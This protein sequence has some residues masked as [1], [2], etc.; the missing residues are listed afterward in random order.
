MM[1]DDGSNEALKNMD[2]HLVDVLYMNA[3]KMS[4]DLGRSAIQR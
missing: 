4:V 3:I 1:L 2:W